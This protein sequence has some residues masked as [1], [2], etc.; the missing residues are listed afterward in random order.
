MP[1]VLGRCRCVNFELRLDLSRLTSRLL[2][3]LRAN[4]RTR[5]HLA[6]KNA[7]AFEQ[8]LIIYKNRSVDHFLVRN[9][10]ERGEYSSA[11]PGT[12]STTVRRVEYITRSRVHSYIGTHLYR[13]STLH[14]LRYGV[15]TGLWESFTSKIPL[16]LLHAD[17]SF[18]IRTPCW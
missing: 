16:A 11:Y 2:G 9:P 17:A 10:L 3:M 14:T 1:R 5:A 8:I 7:R 18:K 13:T 6:A 12:Y 4:A 15:G